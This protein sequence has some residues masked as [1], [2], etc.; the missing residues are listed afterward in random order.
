MKLFVTGGSGFVG[1]HT[2]EQLAKK[3]TVF[4]L[5]RS[6][7]SAN[8]VS[9]YGATPV[10][11]ELGAI[12]PASLQDIDAIIHSGAYVEEWGTR[13]QFWQANVVGTEQLLDAAKKAGVRR[14]IHVGTEAAVFDGHDL[15]NI[16]ETYPYPKQHQY[17]YSETKAA[18]EK[19]VLQA[20][21]EAMTTVSIRPRLV[22]GER[23][24]SVLPT[25]LKRIRENNFAWLDQG[26]TYTSATHVLNLVHALRLALTQ[27]QPGH[28]Y[29]VA[30]EGTMS[31]RAFL[32]QLVNTQ[33]ITPPEMS[34]PSSI[35]RPLSAAIEWAWLTFSLKGTPPMTRF[36]VDMMS[37]T[38][39]VNTIKAQK[40]LGYFPVVTWRKGIEQL[41]NLSG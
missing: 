26:A 34:V 6:E 28:A 16:D 33:R 15:I 4:A 22:W 30:D 8:K 5:A 25:V 3:H 2:I 7:V 36:A 23:D 9:Q 38:I 41:S 12:D 27:G 29:F 11:G 39:T 10:R 31:I 40:D 18:A 21:T 35:A 14:F 19:A 13:E 32:T 24:T 17:L 20:N 1:G 37:S